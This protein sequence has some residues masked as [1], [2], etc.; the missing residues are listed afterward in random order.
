MA[1]VVIFGIQDF[2]L[3]AHF[4]LKHD[5]E[6]ETVAFSVSEDYMPEERTLEGLPVVPFEEIEERYSPSEYKFFAPMSPT[7]MNQLRK[8]TYDQI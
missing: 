7:K 3:L 5:S 4:Y 2:A 8:S 1:R 6:H